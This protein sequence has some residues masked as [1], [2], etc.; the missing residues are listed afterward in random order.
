MAW[1][2][3]QDPGAI[4]AVLPSVAAADGHR[5]V[6]EVDWMPFSE[7]HIYEAA[8]AVV[9]GRVVEQRF[10]FHRTYP[11]D[12]EKG[13]ALTPEE[14]GEEYA[15][16]PVTTSRVAVVERFSDARGGMER[17]STIEVVQLGGRYADGCWVEPNEQPLLRIDDELVAFL[18]PADMVPMG[19]VDDGAYA[20]VGGQQGMV[21][22]RAGLLDPIPDT[23]FTRYA[24]RPVADLARD[25]DGFAKAPSRGGQ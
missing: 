21:P 4:E 6:L 9:R 18:K 10:G 15:E 25:F 22:I 17:R 14:A 3:G 12:P 8:V 20:V 11:F 23:V 1:G 24:R 5:H 13:R 16:L 19:A 2:C 7:A